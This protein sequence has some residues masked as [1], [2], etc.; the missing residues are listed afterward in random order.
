MEMKKTLKQHKSF[1]LK[2]II[3]CVC[4]FVT[5]IAS[6]HYIENR[7]LA[8]Y[9]YEI[10]RHEAALTYNEYKCELVKE[11][12]HYIDSVAP[13]SSLNAYAVVEKCEQY[14][15]DVKF[16]LAQGHL[17]SHFGTTGM[18]AKTNSVFNV[19]AFDNATISEIHEKHKYKHPDYSIEPYMQLLYKDFISGNKTEMDLM[20]KYVTKKGG[21]Y[22][23]NPN[24]EHQLFDLYKK[25]DKTTNITEL[26][27]EMRRYKI[28]SGN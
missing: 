2:S 15:L 3:V 13:T 8:N 22:A 6:H 18:A 26:Q 24:Y 12:K 5:I 9:P 16:V 28:I 4:V 21:R 11:V 20:V 27:A 19:G 14:D 17:E 25:I 7:K 23:T 10:F 1:I